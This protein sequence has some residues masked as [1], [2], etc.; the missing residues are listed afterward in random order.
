M[1][2]KLEP[3]HKVLYAII[4]G[5]KFRIN[6]YFQNA[7]YFTNYSQMLTTNTI[8][9]NMFKKEFH[10]L[11]SSYI[12]FHR[13]NIYLR[14]RLNKAIDYFGDQRK[15]NPYIDANIEFD[16]LPL[17]SVLNL[18][19]YYIDTKYTNLYNKLPGEI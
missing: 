16:A 12:E 8:H 1:E 14:I 3:K 17:S 15:L 9:I 11:N 18:R 7:L 5:N 13:Y 6:K 4:D 10:I 2:S 19:A